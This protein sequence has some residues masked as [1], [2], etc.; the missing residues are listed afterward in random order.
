MP[1]TATRDFLLADLGEGL[2]EAT[3][4][5]WQVAVGDVVELNQVLCLV[6]TAKAEVEVPSPWAGRVVALGAEPGD[7]V[8]VGEVLATI[9]LEGGDSE[10]RSEPDPPAEPDPPSE[11]QA[12]QS[13]LVG[14]GHDPSSDR[15][16]RRRGTRG[17]ATRPRAKPPVRKLARELGVALTDVA[18]G[19]GPDGIVTRADVEA[20]A[21]G[22]TIPV[23]GVRARIAEKMTRSH[24]EI[25]TASASV[26]VDCTRLLEVRRRMVD[27][28][29]RVGEDP[30]VTPF[31]LICRVVVQQLAANPHLNASFDETGPVIRLHED[32]HLGIG[33]ATERGLVVTVVQDA[34]RRALL[35][36]AHEMARLAEG[37]RSGSL[38]PSDL[39]GSTFTISNF[40]ALGIDEG[41]PIINHPEAAILGV[42]AIRRRPH[43]VDDQVV[44]RDT[45]TFTLVFDHRVVDGAEVGR[46]LS[47]LRTVIEEPELALLHP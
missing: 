8:Q 6:E 32:V 11:P 9:D 14:Y 46:F 39:T 24:D 43:V 3:I 30:V 27:H 15:S 44:A 12:R 4:V 37:A 26:L 38:S 17:R 29:A 42:G 5:E 16:R 13:T 22:T 41:T 47:G 33:T 21:A 2:E 35:D 40:G 34:Q 1:D 10:P 45:A 31:A 19:S 28:L 20:A 18:P 7:T 23:T 36:L 25:P